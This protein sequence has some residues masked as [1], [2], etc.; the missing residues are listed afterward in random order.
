MDVGCG[1][2]RPLLIASELPFVRVIGIELS[3]SLAR[4]ARA[5]AALVRSRDAAR[6]PIEI[7]VGDATLADAPGD[8]VVYFLYHPFG[9]SLVETFVR[10]LE[11]QCADLACHAFVV[12]YNPVHGDVVDRSPRLT[13]WSADAWP[14][15]ADEIGFGPDLAD[16]VVVWQTVP[17]RYPAKPGARREIVVTGQKA[18]LKD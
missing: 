5:N 18:D 17:E 14:Y 9:Q 6:S 4:M 15:G 8:R 13:R 2:G 1:K 3:P 7:R 10:N 12:Y 16:T 11:R